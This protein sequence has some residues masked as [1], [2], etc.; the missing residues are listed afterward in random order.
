MGFSLMPFRYYR[1]ILFTRFKVG[2]KLG[3]GYE[4]MQG[5][6]EAKTAKGHL[7]P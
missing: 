4:N 7:G 1:F 6:K 2:M 5:L 3:N